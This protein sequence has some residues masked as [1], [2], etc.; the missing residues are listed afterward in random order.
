MSSGKQSPLR[1]ILENLTTGIQEIE[2]AAIVSVEGLPIE[3]IL[4]NEVDEAKI[5]AMTAAILSLGERASM[6]LNKGELEQVLVRGKNGFLAV[7]SAGFN[8]C[9]TVS[10][11]ADAK[12]GLVMHYMTQAAKEIE[13]LI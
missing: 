1:K 12:L 13:K 5:A 3:S 2:A 11:S 8:A 10:A 9:L 7:Q 6:E 4:P